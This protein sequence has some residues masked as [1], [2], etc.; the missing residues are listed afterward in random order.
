MEL[1]AKRADSVS[2]MAALSTAM[3]D[4]AG[5]AVTLAIGSGLASERYLSTLHSRGIPAPSTR[6]DAPCR[7]CLDRPQFYALVAS[8][9]R[10]FPTHKAFVASVNLRK[11]LSQRQIQARWI[12][13]AGESIFI[14]DHQSRRLAVPP[15]DTQLGHPCRQSNPDY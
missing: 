11:S 1:G 8:F 14:R 9:G 13:L 2:P 4:A 7:S 3:V 12:R 6:A 10:R 5:G 15:T